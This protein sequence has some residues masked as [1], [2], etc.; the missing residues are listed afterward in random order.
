ML[1]KYELN[2]KDFLL[3]FLLLFSIFTFNL[4]TKYFE[5][6]NFK[7]N[8]F[9]KVEATV[10]NQYK[11]FK[12]KKSYF[13]LKLSSD[14]FDFYT[15]TWENLKDIK[16]RK[17]NLKIL[18]NKLK[19]LTFLD[20][21][22]GFYTFSFDIKLLREK[23]PKYQISEYLKA[24]HSDEVLKEFFS[25]IFLG[26][27]IS[28]SLR[29]NV[30]GLGIAHLIA[31]SGYHLGVL[32]GFLF[33]VL[34]YPYK[35]FQDKF[36]PYRNRLIDVSFIIFIIL[37][38]YLL[39]TGFIPSLIRAFVMSMITFLFLLKA[40]KII[41]FTNLTITIVSIIA[42]F[43]KI[44]FSIGFWLSVAGVFFIFLFLHHFRDLKKY[45]IFL[46]IHFFL[47]IAMLPLSYY[48]FHQASIY[49]LFS[50][51]LSM[52]FGIFFPLELLLHSFNFGFLF[53][54]ILIKLLTLKIEL[55]Y[56]EISEYF[57]ILYFILA[58]ASIFKKWIFY[59][60][61][62]VLLYEIG[63]KFLI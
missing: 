18:P 23:S 33:F 14:K 59:L 20:Y 62:V 28:K 58:F 25:A 57:L 22:R 11:K 5:F 7:E 51:P 55:K 41:A 6:K 54:F 52:I 37:F 46:F 45:Q 4:T 29:E 50:I 32:W 47:F 38:L 42:F 60:F 48:L 40:I 26:T 36:F 16:E 24:Q 56:A 17:V 61:N 3:L 15:T 30:N 53:D 1:L 2:F 31:I 10:I 63:F 8:S 12:N 39:L 35:F 19:D 34:S 27:N 43:P 13:V 49:Q 9:L 44:V 21:L